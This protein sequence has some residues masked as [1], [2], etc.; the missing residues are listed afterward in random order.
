M[1]LAPFLVHELNGYWPSFDYQKVPLGPLP[2]QLLPALQSLA[3]NACLMLG[4]S[5]QL[6]VPCVA[7]VVV[8]AWRARHRERGGD[9][10]RAGDGGPAGD[11][12]HALARGPAGHALLCAALLLAGHVAMFAMMIARHPYVHAWLDHRYWYY[13]IPWLAVLLFG[14]AV[15]SNALLPRLRSGERRLVQLVLAAIVVGNLASLPHY[16]QLMLGGPW[17]GRVHAQSER[18]EAAVRSGT[19]DPQLEQIYRKFLVYVGTLRARAAD[20]SGR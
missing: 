6:A 1:L 12:A 14:A 8:L 5:W 9:G 2:A 16:R 19:D 7:L 17:F 13:P 18:F 4:G 3:E 11:G 10:A 20:A 15:G